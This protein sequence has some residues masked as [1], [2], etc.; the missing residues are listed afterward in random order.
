M[1]RHLLSVHQNEPK[2]PKAD[3]L[4]RLEIIVLLVKTGGS[5]SAQWKYTTFTDRRL[6]F[7]GLGSFE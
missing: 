4:V 5:I 2:R 3:D 7:G 1:D 6:N